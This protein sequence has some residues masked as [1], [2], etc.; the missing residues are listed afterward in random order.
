MKRVR[1]E[2]QPLPEGWFVKLYVN[3]QWVERGYS[4]VRPMLAVQSAAHF[5]R[6]HRA[7]VRAR[8][9]RFRRTGR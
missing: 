5:Y 6:E 7:K 4:S 3:D 9:E 8:R 1:F 2:V